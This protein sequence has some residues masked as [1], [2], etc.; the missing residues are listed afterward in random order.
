MDLHEVLHNTADWLTKDGPS[1]D[2]VLSSRIRVARN[3]ER[4][5]FTSVAS[6]KSF[7]DTAELIRE[8]IEKTKSLSSMILVSVSKISEVDQNVLVERHLISR[9]LI[10]IKG[11]RLI[12]VNPS[13]TISLMVNEE[14]HIRLQGIKE[15][16]QLKELWKVVD[17]IDTEL[18]RVL[19]FAFSVKYGYLTACPTNTGTGMRASVMMHLPALVLTKQINKVIEAVVKLGLTVRG[20]HGE[21]TEATGDFFQ[22]SNQITLGHSEADILDN[23]ERIVKQVIEHEQSAR[24]ILMQE[25]KVQIEDRIW[26]AYGLLKHSRIMTS[27]EAINLMSAVRLGIGLGHIHDIDR[28]VLSVLMILTKPGHIQFQEGREMNSYERD[29]KRASLIRNLFDQAQLN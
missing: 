27:E 3:L 8:G 11:E 28:K 25:T 2:I 17:E 22:I 23:I 9:D 21:G 29:V 14:D 26:R 19:E 20:L 18:E 1:S 15:G 7:K 5:S 13:Q 4:M 12:V 6:E 16:F 10:E 24:K